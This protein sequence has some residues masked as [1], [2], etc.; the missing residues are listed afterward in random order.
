MSHTFSQQ[1]FC[2][3]RSFYG[4]NGKVC[5][6]TTSHFGT[7]YNILQ[8]KPNRSSIWTVLPL[9]ILT[10]ER[11]ASRG[12]GSRLHRIDIC[13][14]NASVACYAWRPNLHK[15]YN[16]SPVGWSTAPAKLDIQGS[17]ELALSFITPLTSS[18]QASKQEPLLRKQVQLVFRAPLHWRIKRKLDLFRIGWEYWPFS[19]AAMFLRL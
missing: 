18:S 2:L 9:K 7:L 6:M 19:V 3:T 4:L 15:P 1:L 14:P 13:C 16:A 11:P 17:R 12:I 10:Q 8:A 5:K